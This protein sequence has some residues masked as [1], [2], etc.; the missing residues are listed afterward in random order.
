MIHVECVE[1]FPLF[2]LMKQIHSVECECA[3]CF[4]FQRLHHNIIHLLHIALIMSK[5]TC[6]ECSHVIETVK[7]LL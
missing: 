1:Y 2:Q 7:H 6:P 4:E 3:R 5:Q